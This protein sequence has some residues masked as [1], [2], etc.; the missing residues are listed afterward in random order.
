[1][2]KKLKKG[3]TV[4]L[5]SQVCFTIAD[6]GGLERRLKGGT[7]YLTREGTYFFTERPSTFEERQAFYDSPMSKGITEAGETRL[8]PMTTS[9]L[10]K[11]GSRYVVLRARCRVE[12][13]YRRGPRSGMAHIQCVA[14]GENTYIKREF[15]EVV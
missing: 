6:G 15:L 8:A 5:N 14:T 1:M 7:G 2:M 11:R 3:C 10:M 4:Q 13:G 12:L 9:F